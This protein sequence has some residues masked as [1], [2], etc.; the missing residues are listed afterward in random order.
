MGLF[1]NYRTQSATAMKTDLPLPRASAA[2]GSKHENV[3]ERVSSTGCEEGGGGTRGRN[4]VPKP[5]TR[6]KAFI[7]KRDQ[8]I[9]V[10][11]ARKAILKSEQAIAET[12]RRRV[13]LVRAV[14]RARGSQ[15][16]SFEDRGNIYRIYILGGKIPGQSSNSRDLA[17]H[18]NARSQNRPCHVIDHL[19]QF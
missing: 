10:L 15:I 14:F 9:A 8:Q 7:V 13:S 18:L 1:P 17:F 6:I 5:P 12:V 3:S 16:G 4:R 11:D 2:L 19:A